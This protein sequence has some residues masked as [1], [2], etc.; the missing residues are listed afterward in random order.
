[1]SK[2][3]ETRI[4]KNKGLS[5]NGSVLMM[6]ALLTAALGMVGDTIITPGADAMFQILQSR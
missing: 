1:M 2:L 6:A 5:K 3:P 4:D